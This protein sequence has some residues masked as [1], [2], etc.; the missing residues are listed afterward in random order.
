MA[1][2]IGFACGARL[3]DCCLRLQVEVWS[4][5]ISCKFGCCW[6]LFPPWFRMNF[7]QQMKGVTIQLQDSS[8]PCS[9][10]PQHSNYKFAELQY[11]EP[12]RRCALGATHSA[13]SWSAPFV[14]EHAGTNIESLCCALQST[15]KLQRNSWHLWP[16][17]DR[18]CIQRRA[19]I[20]KRVLR[21]SGQACLHP[22]CKL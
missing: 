7:R 19:R 17:R 1:C 5:A 18:R 16:Q 3:E 11:N 12:L 22:D 15:P 20:W 10:L 14:W 6:Q 21:A 4:S 13:C 9:C 2:A 8:A